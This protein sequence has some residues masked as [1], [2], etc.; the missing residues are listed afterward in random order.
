MHWS[1]RN[2]GWCMHLRWR[3]GHLP[4]QHMEV[5]TDSIVGW[6]WWWGASASRH[7]GCLRSTIR[8]PERF[9]IIR[10]SNPSTQGDFL[11]PLCFPSFRRIE[12]NV[13][14]RV[15]IGWT[16]PTLSSPRTPPIHFGRGSQRLMGLRLMATTSVV[17]MMMMCYIIR[18]Q[19]PVT[20]AGVSRT[21]KRITRFKRVSISSSTSLSSADATTR[22]AV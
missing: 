2:Y 21:P 19:M 6:R 17:M 8:R 15:L 9:R 18:R 5:M 10:L 22:A 3:D 12:K 16:R 4:Q 7:A 20:W 1:S 11:P 13:H 14:A